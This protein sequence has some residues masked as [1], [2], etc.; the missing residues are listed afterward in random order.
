[1]CPLQME[2]QA[3]SGASSQAEKIRLNWHPILINFTFHKE[4]RIL[5]RE[6]QPLDVMG[7]EGTGYLATEILYAVAKFSIMTPNQIYSTKYDL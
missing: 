2:L 3:D 6:G 5:H 1:M 7:T 4:C